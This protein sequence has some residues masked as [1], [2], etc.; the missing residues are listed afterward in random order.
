VMLEIELYLMMGGCLV[1]TGS[2]VGIWRG[3][4]IH[5]WRIRLAA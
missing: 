3:V 1:V 5:L 4:F 2:Y